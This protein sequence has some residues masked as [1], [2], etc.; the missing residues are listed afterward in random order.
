MPQSILVVEDYADLRSAIVTALLRH[1]Y[2][3]EQVKSSE[4]AIEKLRD[5]HY[6]AIL[7]APMLPISSDPVMH[8]LVEEQPDQLAKVVM[9]GDP[10][11]EDDAGAADRPVLLKPF[12][13]EQLCAQILR[14]RT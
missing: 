2:S 6:S 5:K 8:F 10:E 4:E 7:L 11:M 3:C 14:T 13:D 12:N 9:M 1:R